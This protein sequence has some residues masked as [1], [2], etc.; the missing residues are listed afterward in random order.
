M[1][2]NMHCGASKTIFQ[3]A[4]VLR[5]NMTEAEKIIWEQLCKNQL[6]V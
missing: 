2:T 4:D 1:A 3:Y 5:K 6:D